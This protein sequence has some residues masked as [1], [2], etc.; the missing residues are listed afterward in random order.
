MPLYSEKQALHI[1]RGGQGT[2]KIAMAAFGF[3]GVKEER[4]NLIAA[5]FCS[6]YE[7]TCKHKQPV[8]GK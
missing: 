8:I 3:Y 6:E 2:I 4:K 1:P 5:Q 7:P